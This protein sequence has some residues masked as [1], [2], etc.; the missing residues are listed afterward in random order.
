MENGRGVES[1]TAESPYPDPSLGRLDG[2][3]LLIVMRVP[4]V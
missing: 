1:W 2:G 3:T 4:P